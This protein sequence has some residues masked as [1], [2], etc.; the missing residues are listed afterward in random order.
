VAS[1]GI[2]EGVVVVLVVPEVLDVLGLIVDESELLMKFTPPV[3][4]PERDEEEVL[5]KAR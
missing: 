4:F 2:V 1:L 5:L 3:L